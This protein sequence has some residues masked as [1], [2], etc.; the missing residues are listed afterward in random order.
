[1]LSIPRNV[2]LVIC[3]LVS[4]TS[5]LP[6][7]DADGFQPLFNGRDLKGWVNCNVAPTTFSVKDGLI[8]STGIPT[9][10]MRTDRMYENF[11]LEAEWRHMQPKGNAGI[12]VWADSLT[13]PGVPFSRSIEV[14]VLDGLN[15][16]SYTSH[17]DIFSIHGA[18]MLP[19]RP[20]PNGSQRCL[21]S[22]QR[23]KPSPEWNHYRIECNDGVISLAVN[24]KVVSGGSKCLPRKGFICLESEG[25]ECHFRNVKIKEMPSTQAKPEETAKGDDG[26]HSLYTG[27]DLAGW[28]ADAGHSPH[29]KA[30]DWRLLCLAKSG[31]GKSEAADPSLWSEKEY[32]DCILICDWRLPRKAQPKSFAGILPSGEADLEN[33]QPKTVEAAD[34]GM[35]GI[36]LRGSRKSE[37]QI[38]GHPVGSGLIDGYRTD[39]TT[40][41]ELR[42]AV[43]PKLRADRPAGQWNRFVIT[44]K[45]ER[46][47]VVLNGQTVIEDAA[48]VGLPK[49]G[50]LGLL[51]HGDAVEFANIYIKELD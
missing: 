15:T 21:P 19:D 37:I 32:G 25:S 28:Q 50:K 8:V 2:C 36:A 48:L 17:G 6:A 14:Q 20:H 40:T 23:C 24:G 5:T 35:S 51:H 11:I 10:V 41:T 22:E 46:V 45:G 39:K 33:G 30:S 27:L 34:A 9:G 38:G 47:S 42:R 44:L 16:A 18:S 49:R 7:A 3:L 26:F 43:T 12:F 4:L 31:D 29:W 1:M 13:A